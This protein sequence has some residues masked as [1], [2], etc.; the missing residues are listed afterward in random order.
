[1]STQNKRKASEERY[2]YSW[3]LPV[4]GGE[5]TGAHPMAADTME[6]EDQPEE[7]MQVNTEYLPVE[8][9]SSGQK[10]A[11]DMHLKLSG[12]SLKLLGLA[13]WSAVAGGG[14][15]ALLATRSSF[16]TDNVIAL[17]GVWAGLSALIWFLPDIMTKKGQTSES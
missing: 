10:G 15:I 11:L 12:S 16:A 6:I 8:Q 3:Y 2:I 14:L 4:P 17:C 1:M 9:V 7:P 13:G 5:K